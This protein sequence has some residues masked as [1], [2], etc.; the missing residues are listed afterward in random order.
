MAPK[1]KG[2]SGA[3]TVGHGGDV[4]AYVS[5]RRLRRRKGDALPWGE[6]ETMGRYAAEIRDPG[7]KGGSG[8]ARST[9][10]RRQPGHTT[11]P[12]EI[13]GDRRRGLTF[14]TPASAARAAAPVSSF[15]EVQ[16]ARAAR[17][18]PPAEA[19]AVLPPLAFPC[20]FL[21][22]SSPQRQRTAVS[23][24]SSLDRPRP[25]WC[26]RLFCLMPS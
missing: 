16:A 6:E 10:R 2:R 13:F 8:L 20:S 5:R 4:R 1:L 18:S 26:N 11:P 19:A 14:P 3:K 23:V 24:S 21:S 22:R 15:R 12:L 17:W 9:R 7:K 25:R